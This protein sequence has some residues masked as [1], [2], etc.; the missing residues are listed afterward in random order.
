MQKTYGQ[1]EF[2]NDVMVKKFQQL[3]GNDEIQVGF[4]R[5]AEKMQVIMTC[6]FFLNTRGVG[7]QFPLFLQT[8]NLH[9]TIPRP[10]IIRF[11]KEC[12][13]WYTN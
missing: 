13:R 7:T 3:D 2:G 12:A 9:E 11:V 1:I 5:G 8:G 10:K 4:T 6:M